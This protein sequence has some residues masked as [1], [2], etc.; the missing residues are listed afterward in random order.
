MSKPKVCDFEA[1]VRGEELVLDFEVAVEAFV[2]MKLGERARDIGCKGESE[3]PRQRL[4][5]IM[6]E[7]AKIA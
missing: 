6:N 2:R 4:G 1:T 7:L 3:T 5:F